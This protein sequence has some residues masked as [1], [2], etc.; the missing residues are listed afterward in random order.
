MITT[1]CVLNHNMFRTFL[2]RRTMVIQERPSVRS[3][4]G[5]QTWRTRGCR[6]ARLGEPPPSSPTTVPWRC[7]RR[8]ARRGG[9]DVP[10]PASSLPPAPPAPPRPTPRR[11]RRDLRQVRPA[12]PQRW[13]FALRA[14][15]AMG[16]PVAVGTWAGQPGAGL[17]A[18]LGAFTALYGGGR[19]YASRAITLAVVA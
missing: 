14:A 13:A 18:T 12:P 8:R 2:L 9:E 17:M 7:V 1:R 11:L 5:T 4:P 15:L 19:P 6:V 16:I 10:M 3:L